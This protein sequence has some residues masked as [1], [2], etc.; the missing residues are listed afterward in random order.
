MGGAE[1]VQEILTLFLED[2]PL[3]VSRVAA[4]IERNDALTVSREG[5]SLKGGCRQVGAESLAKLAEQW[6]YGPPEP[7]QWR[8]LLAAFEQEFVAVESLVRAHPLFGA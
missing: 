6:E 2:V 7:A 1:V 5:H 4:A 8:S 3:R